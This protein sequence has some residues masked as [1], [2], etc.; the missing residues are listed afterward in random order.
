MLAITMAVNSYNT[1][2]GS[3]RDNDNILIRLRFVVLVIHHTIYTKYATGRTTLPVNYNMLHG[4]C[5]VCF[6]I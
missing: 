3:E 1:D 2:V 6:A 5:S 4:Q